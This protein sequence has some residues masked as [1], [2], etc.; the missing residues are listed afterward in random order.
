MNQ[1]KPSS[2]DIDHLKWLASVGIGSLQG[3]RVLDLGCGSG[4][5]CHQAVKDGATSA[6]GIDIIK[7]RYFD[8]NSKWIFLE[9][10]LDGDDWIKQIP[11]QEFDLVL[12]FDILEH[13]ESPYRFV[14]AIRSV[15]SKNATLVLTTPNTQS[16]ERFIKPSSWSGA[17]DIQH[18]VLFNRY[19]LKFLLAR[20]GFKCTQ[21]KAPMR[22]L[23]PL[24]VLQPQIGGQ[25]ICLAQVNQA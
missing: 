5:I 21:L 25:I 16:W 14:S 18:K 8:E 1:L 2:S 3:L 22:S 17:Q 4:F 15:M 24:G 10:N 12:A 9:S 11:Q 19:S 7:P 13:L 6:I 23:T 20:A